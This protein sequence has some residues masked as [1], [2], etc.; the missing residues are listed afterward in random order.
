MASQEEVFPRGGG[1]QLSGAAKK[2]LRE[3]GE[4]A[5]LRDF[6]AE[7]KRVKRKKKPLDVRRC[8][9][10]FTDAGVTS[11]AALLLDQQQHCA[12][13]CRCK[14][15]GMPLRHCVLRCGLLV[16]EAVG[17]DEELDA[18]Q[19]LSAGPGS[20]HVPTLRFKVKAGTKHACILR[21]VCIRLAGTPVNS[22]SASAQ[23]RGYSTLHLPQ[24]HGYHVKHASA[25]TVVLC[26]E[27]WRLQS[28]SVGAK[29][30]GVVSEIGPHELTV[31]LPHGLR[32]YVAAKEVRTGS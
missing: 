7:E 14:V 9:P 3:Q 12:P 16:Q 25:C 30:L 11:S 19:G 17:S 20:K 10:V 31:T 15:A 23:A 5:A 29:I 13:M 2:R 6:E 4:A 24:L 8:T 27:T 32:G 21:E 28:L 18:F 22:S 26:S 1:R